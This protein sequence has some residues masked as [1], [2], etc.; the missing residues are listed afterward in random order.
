MAEHDG[1]SRRE[2]GASRDGRA[3]TWNLRDVG[4]QRLNPTRKSN[5]QRVRPRE[6]QSRTASSLRECPQRTLYGRCLQTER[7]GTRAGTCSAHRDFK[8]RRV[9]LAVA[10]PWVS[11]SAYLSSQS[12]ANSR[13]GLHPGIPIPFFS[14]GK[15]LF[16]DVEFFLSVKRLEPQKEIQSENPESPKKKQR[17][18]GRRLGGCSRGAVE[19]QPRC[20]RGAESRLS[21]MVRDPGI[22]VVLRDYPRLPELRRSSS[23]RTFR[24]PTR[25]GSAPSSPPSPRRW[26]TSTR[27]L[28]QIKALPGSPRTP[29]RSARCGGGGGGG[30]CGEGPRAERNGGRA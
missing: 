13:S 3:R 4:Q 8:E 16:P 29:S 15:I 7:A 20:S 22:V 21:Y 18:K 10:H 11:A 2:A 23:T 26:S 1:R 30:G 9:V 12:L 6:W 24:G 17:K 14:R 25:T 19:V 28:A 27:Q 5:R